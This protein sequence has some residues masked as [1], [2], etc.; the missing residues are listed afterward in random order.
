MRSSTKNQI[1]G[2]IHEING[3]VKEKLGQAASDSQL[4][5]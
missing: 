2:K 3:N 4:A 1:L 5:D